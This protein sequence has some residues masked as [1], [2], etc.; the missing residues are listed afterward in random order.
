MGFV[1]L[2]A[3]I[4]QVDLPLVDRFLAFHPISFAF[5]IF[6]ITGVA[7]AVN[8][9]DGLNGLSGIN[10]LLASIGLA[11]IGWVVDDVFI[12][13]SACLLAGAIAGFFAV[14]FPSGRIFLGDGGA[15]LIG[16]LLALLSV[17][18]VHRNIE[19]S[20]WF[21]LVL[22]W[23]PI[24]E[25]LYSMYRRKVRGRSTGSADALHLHTLVY[26]R[27]V[28]WKGPAATPAEA[29]VRNSLASL[30]LWSL[31]FIGLGVG[32]A[33]WNRSILLEAFALLFAIAYIVGY[34]R[35]VRFKLPKWLLVRAPASAGVTNL[36]HSAVLGAGTEDS[37]TAE[38]R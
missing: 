9:I 7:N 30:C 20:A 22:L 26:R 5:T 1:L 11:A 8:V 38:S 3:R 10:G 33:F 4:T 19:V 32:L 24:W 36:Q 12:F 25:T 21:P 29:V 14:N 13:Q 34:S 15:Y 31:P 18:L 17:M 37:A 28:R 6:A 27:I 2:D 35:I 16:L 23:Y